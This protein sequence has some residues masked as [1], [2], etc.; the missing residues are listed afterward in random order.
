MQADRLR[1]RLDAG[2][3]PYGIITG[4]ADPDVVEAAGG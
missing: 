3:V 2:E 1:Q 4:W